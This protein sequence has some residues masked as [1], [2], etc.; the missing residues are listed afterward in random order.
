MSEVL[1][2][3]SVNF[4]SAIRRDTRSRKCGS[5][6][7][8]ASPALSVQKLL[9]TSGFVTDMWSSGMSMMSGHVG[10]VIPR[11]GVVENVR[12]AVEFSFVVVYKL[13]ML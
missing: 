12:V 2:L 7:G 1:R 10:G 8:I 13:F 11:S 9:S 3:S 6:V 4:L 5:T